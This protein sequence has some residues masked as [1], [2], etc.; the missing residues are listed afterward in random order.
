MPVA[1]GGAGQG[2]GGARPPQAAPPGV[3][4]V[5]GRE[6][7]DLAAGNWSRGCGGCSVVS[8]R[9]M[10]VYLVAGSATGC[11]HPFAGPGVAGLHGAGPRQRRRSGGVNQIGARAAP[12]AAGQTDRRPRAWPLARKAVHAARAGSRAAGGSPGPG[13]QRIWPSRRP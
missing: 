6:P 9:P 11:S 1:S 10:A 3:L 13:R 5:T 2:P 4:E 12:G 7:D 8:V